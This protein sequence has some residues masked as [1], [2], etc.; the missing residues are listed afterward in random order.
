MKN[1]FSIIIPTYKSKDY[2]DLCLY[3]ISRVENIKEICEVIV[4]CDGHY[5][6]VKEAIDKYVDKLDL[7]YLNLPKVGMAKAINFAVYNAKYEHLLV[8][9]DDN[10]VPLNINTICDNIN[11]F[12]YGII[13]F[14]QIEP[15]PSIFS[16]HYIEDLGETFDKFDFERFDILTEYPNY[17]GD[18]ENLECI[19]DNSFEPHLGTFPFLISKDSFMRSGGFDSD[20]NSPFVTDWDFF[21]K[22]DGNCH[23]KT[24]H[25]FYHFSSKSSSN[26]EVKQTEQQ[27]H[28]YFKFKWGRYGKINNDQTSYL[29]QI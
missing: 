22:F 14:P 9:N 15:K 20:Y 23:I 26:P 3:S 29:G 10:V 16:C 17:H 19:T 18:Y 13:S 12:D 28:E 2:L 7:K 24:E 5:D 25:Y 6:I 21:V 11:C 1:K 4:S 8:I 27:A